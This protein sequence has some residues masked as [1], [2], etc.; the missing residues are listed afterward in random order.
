MKAKKAA[1]RRPWRSNTSGFTGAGFRGLLFRLN[2]GLFAFDVSLAALFMFCFVVLLSHMLLYFIRGLRF[3][4][5][6]MNFYGRRFNL[7]LLFAVALLTAA[8]CATTKNPDK[9]LAILRLHIESNASVPGSSQTISVLRNTPLAVTIGV[10]PVLTEG[11]IVAAVLLD[12]PGGF[13]VEVKFD[14]IGTLTL[15]QYTAAYAGKHFAIFGQWCDK[16]VE[17]RWLAAPIISGRI[18]NG[19][20]SF[21][22]DAS[23]EEAIKLVR[24]LNNMAKKVAKEGAKF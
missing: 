23:R 5:S 24:G 4:V 2:D 22:V 12:T 21:S 3:R 8:G 20:L 9:Q 15:E 6:T 13:A 7:Y 16:P 14:E 11:S 19:V 1:R 18:A 17:G 10:Q